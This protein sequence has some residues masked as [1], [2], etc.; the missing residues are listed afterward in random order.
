MLTVGLC[1]VF[2]TAPFASKGSAHLTM[3]RAVVP[4]L[5]P[6]PNSDAEVQHSRQCPILLSLLA[7]VIALEFHVVLRNTGRPGHET[8]TK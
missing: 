3:P 6:T 1:F 4:M 8:S 2:I 5:S 7:S